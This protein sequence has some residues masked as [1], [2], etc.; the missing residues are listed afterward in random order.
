MPV[1][2]L[3][4]LDRVLH[5]RMPP[6]AAPI[7]MLPLQ[8]LT[9]LAVEDSRFASDA[10]RLM[11]Q[12]SGARLRRVDTLQA[13]YAHLRVYRPDVMMV[14]LGLPDGRGDALIC[15][16]AR[17]RP[18]G[19]IIIGIS[20]DTGGHAVAMMAGAHGFIEKPFPSL[21]GF[22]AA[23]L[24]HLPDR[25]DRPLPNAGEVTPRADPL[26]LRDDLEHAA[27]LLRSAPA[28]GQRRYLAG[29]VT[30]IARS[31]NDPALAAAASTLADAE[32]LEGLRLLLDARLN[33]TAG[34]FGGA[35]I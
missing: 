1:S 15:D 17:L 29:F 27:V 21:A 19:P 5:G 30:G 25:A 10:L 24:R 12:R 16:L 9:L 4:L 26:A 14:D 7:A 3:G 18:E 33:A 11:C 8:G 2:P 34:P 23:I 28:R 22:Q 32:G 13:A 35:V 31:A 20:G 6:A